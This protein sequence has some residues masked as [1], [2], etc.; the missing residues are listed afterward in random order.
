[1]HSSSEGAGSGGGGGHGI[2]LKYMQNSELCKYLTAQRTPTS[3]NKSISGMWHGGGK[4]LEIL[5]IQ[6][7]LFYII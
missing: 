6:F 4:C 3:I 7:L 2:K 5:Y 1:M